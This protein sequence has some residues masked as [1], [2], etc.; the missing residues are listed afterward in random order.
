MALGFFTDDNSS[1]SY[2]ASQRRRKLADALLAQS[3]DGAPIQSWTQG[4]A[5]LLQ[6]L[7]G[8]L[9]NNRLDA[10]E[11]ETTGAFNKTLASIL[12]GGSSSAPAPSQ[13]APA[14]APD[15]DM[16]KWREAIAKKESAGSGDY[17]AVGPTHQKLGRA[18]GRY[19]VM[20]ANIGPWSREALGREVTADEFVKNPQIQDAIFNHRF[21]QYVK[22]YGNPQDAASAWFT[23]RPQAQGANARDVLG[24]TGAQ[25]V[26]DFNRNIG[27]PQPAPVQ[28]ASAGGMTPD[29]MP[30]SPVPSNA[31]AMSF[32]PGQQAISAAAPQQPPARQQLAQ[33]VAPSTSPQIPA[34]QPQGNVAAAMAAILADPRFSPQQKNQALQL[35]QMQQQQANRNP[36][37]IPEGGRAVVPDGRGGFREVAVGAPKMSDQERQYEAAR[38]GGF[39]GSFFDYQSQLR[40]AGATNVN[41]NPGDNKFK[42]TIGTET[43]KLFVEAAK[44]GPN[45]RAD[46][47]QVRQLRGLVESLPGGFVGGAQALASRY[48][49]KIGPNAGNI[50]AAEAIINRLVPTQRPPGSGTMSDRDV[51]LFKS[52]LPSLSNTPQGNKIIL[53]TMEA[54]AQYKAAQAEI[55]SAVVTEQ[56]D[57]NEGMRRLQALPDP[58]EAFKGYAAAQPVQRTTAPRPPAP[59][60]FSDDEIQAEMR[61]RGL[62]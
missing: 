4:G 18:L 30:T 26:S 53:D 43:G 37:I 55:A 13:S 16:A 25:Y 49:V 10:R 48:G 51:E 17:S 33:A 35:F 12:G 56:I 38:R 3:Q 61:R 28:V 23:G 27:Q 6:A 9:M 42:D 15:G 19:Q 29:G 57:R 20:E 2:E 58:F 7:S 24:T 11:R 46:V 44:E 54:M 14:P 52:S 21:G 45:A 22:Q 47:G 31:P 1:D 40:R 8:T 62:R 36:M 41:V 32:A 34:P 60:E 5:K 39:Q 50:E 59:G